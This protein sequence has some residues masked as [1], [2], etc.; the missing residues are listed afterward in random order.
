MF[1]LICL[2]SIHTIQ[3]NMHIT[4]TIQGRCQCVYFNR[5][6]GEGKHFA[7]S[8]KISTVQKQPGGTAVVKIL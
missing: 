3:Y 5:T 1:Q 7:L 2:G 4:L 8:A 6:L